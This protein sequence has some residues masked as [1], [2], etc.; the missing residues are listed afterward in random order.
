[1]GKKG[2]NSVKHRYKG[3][4]YG[5]NGKGDYVVLPLGVSDLDSP[6]AFPVKPGFSGSSDDEKMKKWARE[7]IDFLTTLEEGYEHIA[8]N[9]FRESS[10]DKGPDGT[11]QSGAYPKVSW[12]VKIDNG[13]IYI[14]DARISSNGVFYLRPQPQEWKKATQKQVRLLN[15]LTVMK[16]I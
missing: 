12:W 6:S 16:V 2:K 9:V 4:Y 1:M 3:L 5:R 13:V 11:V 8:G 15:H 10:G 7:H 14:A